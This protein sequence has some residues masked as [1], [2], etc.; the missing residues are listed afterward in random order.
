MRYLSVLTRSVK[1]I[2]WEHIKEYFDRDPNYKDHLKVVNRKS[3]LETPAQGIFFKGVS[4]EKL[5][6]SPDNYIGNIRAFSSL[7]RVGWKESAFIEFVQDDE[8]NLY[9]PIFEEDI[10]DQITSSNFTFYTQQTPIIKQKIENRQPYYADSPENIQVKV[11]GVEVDVTTVEGRTGK[12]LL[13]QIPPLGSVLTVS[14]LKRKLAP[15]GYYFFELDEDKKMYMGSYK[16]ENDFPIA[17]KIRD[18]K[19]TFP[20]GYLKNNSV[21]IFLD[22]SELETGFSVVKSGGFI[23][24]TDLP[25]GE[26]IVVRHANTNTVLNAGVKWFYKKWEE[27]VLKTASIGN[28]QYFYINKTDVSNLNVYINGR[29]LDKSEYTFINRR[30]SLKSFP[31][32][33]SEIKADYVYRSTTVEPVVDVSSIFHDNCKF[34]LPYGNLVSEYFEAYRNLGLINSSEYTVDY[35]AG[36]VTFKKLLIDKPYLVCFRWYEGTTGPFDVIPRTWNNTILPGVILYFGDIFIPDDK[37]VVLVGDQQKEC[38]DE[39]GGKWRINIEIGIKTL[40]PIETDILT[41]KL[42]MYLWGMLKQDFDSRGLFIEDVSHSGETE[43]EISESTGDTDF[44][45]TISMSLYTDWWLRVPRKFRLMSISTAIEPV[46]DKSWR[47]EGVFLPGFN[48]TGIK[49]LDT[50]E[51]Y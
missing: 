51:R 32:Q 16:A 37:T 47:V 20:T 35:T 31:K 42:I 7:A 26:R 23:Q 19:F 9:T 3:D 21:K 11:N 2:L 4:A 43:E 36:E 18:I 28:E 29:L 46:F 38:A 6:L 49:Y 5:Q 22:G 8:D 12:F 14:Y 50:L 13:K 30:L 34:K 24:F 33:G 10:S 1:Q 25:E 41:D 15:N 45:T 17:P 27:V 40:S 44:Q 48:T 39:Y